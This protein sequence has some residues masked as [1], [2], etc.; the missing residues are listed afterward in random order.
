MDDLKGKLSYLDG[1]SNVDFALAAHAWLRN[2][3]RAAVLGGTLVGGSRLVQTELA[4]RLGVSTTPVREALRDL[5]SEGL[6][7]FDP[8]RGALVRSLDM[9][10]V[11]ELYELRMILEPVMIRR[12]IDMITPEQLALAEVIQ[13]RMEEPC[14]TSTWADLNRDFHAVFNTV[15]GSSRLAS[16]IEGL[17]DSAAS[18][19]ALSLNARPQQ[20]AE[21]NAEHARLVSL[22]RKRDC[23]G[24]I[25]LTLVHF[26][27]TLAAIEEA[28][29]S[30]KR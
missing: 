1:R 25:A 2:A 15:D 7:V 11:R 29:Q 30:V 27:A 5:A 13:R 24:V 3:L 19:V 22:Y 28:H 12:V 17:R 23:D 26:R 20:I 9:A 21:A 16:L 10:E 8:H 18:Y 4:E 6:V 14:D